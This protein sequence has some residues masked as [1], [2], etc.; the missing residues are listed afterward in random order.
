MMPYFFKI[1]FPGNPI[2]T[3]CAATKTEADDMERALITLKADYV[4]VGPEI[5]LA[6]LVSPL[7]ACA[8]A[9]QRNVDWLGRFPLAMWPHWKHSRLVFLGSTKITGTPSRRAL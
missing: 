9:R 8:H 4:I 5:T 7:S 6:A 2:V 1:S 3:L